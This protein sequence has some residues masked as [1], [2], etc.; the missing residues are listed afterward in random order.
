[1]G[2]CRSR[3][4]LPV[5]RNKMGVGGWEGSGAGAVRGAGRGRGGGDDRDGYHAYVIDHSHVRKF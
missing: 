2:V 5:T 3:V 1:M 4:C